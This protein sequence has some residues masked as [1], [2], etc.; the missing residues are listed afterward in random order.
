MSARFPNLSLVIV[1]AA[2]GRPSW[3]SPG[4]TDFSLCL[5]PL[6]RG[7]VTSDCALGFL[8]GSAGLR[9]GPSFHQVP[10]TPNPRVGLAVSS[11]SCV[12][13]TSGRLFRFRRGPALLDPMFARSP[14]LADSRLFLHCHP[15]RSIGAFCRCSAEGSLSDSPHEPAP[16]P[17]LAHN[18]SFQ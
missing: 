17:P 7:T 12:G 5:G 11:L 10:H 1:G 9:A 16:A 4:S 13:A 6:L 8:L 2:S 14:R 15:D 18:T 3:V